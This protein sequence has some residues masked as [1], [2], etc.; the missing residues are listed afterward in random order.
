MAGIAPKIAANGRYTDAA[1][2]RA[3]FPDGRMGSDPTLAMPADGEVLIGL[4]AAGL[5]ADYGLFLS[6]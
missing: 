4:S 2:F 5:A 1:D 6:N 3:K